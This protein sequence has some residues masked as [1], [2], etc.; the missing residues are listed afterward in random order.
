MTRQALSR[1][2]D[3]VQLRAEAGQRLLQTYAALAA[4]GAHLLGHVLGGQAPR[5]WDHYPEHD[6]IDHASGYQWFYHSHH[7]E[8]RAGAAEH[9]HIHL[10]ARQPLWSRRLHSRNERAFADLCGYPEARPATRHLLGVSFDAKG[11][12]VSLFTVNSW[13][14]GDLM[15][16]ADLTLDLLDR[17]A[18][19]TGY[20]EVDAVLE[21][22]VRLCG[23][24]LRELMHRRD[25]ALRAHPGPGKLQDEALELLAEMPID[26]DSKL[27]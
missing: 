24:E 12:P 1:W 13:V 20:P 16:S 11:L 7:P 21:T 15:L 10:F 19:D 27:G 4:R 8:D 17:M 6:A 23:P 14:T 25:A 2:R 18:L 5:Q 3:P 22:V 9:G 26:L